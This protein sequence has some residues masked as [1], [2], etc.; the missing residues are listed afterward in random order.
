VLSDRSQL[1]SH[2]K[3]LWQSRKVP[4]RGSRCLFV[5]VALASGSAVEWR[6]YDYRDFYFPCCSAYVTTHRSVDDD[7]ENAAFAQRLD[8]LRGSLECGLFRLSPSL[9]DAVHPGRL[10][11]IVATKRHG[12]GIGSHARGK[13]APWSC[14]GWLAQDTL[15]GCRTRGGMVVVMVVTGCPIS[16]ELELCV[17][18]GDVWLPR[19]VHA[20]KVVFFVIA[21]SSNA[22]AATP[23][24]VRKRGG[25]K[26]VRVPAVVRISEH[27]VQFCRGDNKTD[28]K[29]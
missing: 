23:M 6:R 14:C 2:R 24:Y 25:S 1:W 8:G 4:D 10:R 9:Q 7:A 20:D 22:L 5:D 21:E 19:C 18:D 12:G 28:S 16:I 29:L 17:G 27:S 13:P 15:P 11:D 26:R 3:P